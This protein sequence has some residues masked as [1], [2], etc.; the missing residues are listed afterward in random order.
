MDDAIVADSA[1]DAV[2]AMEVQ[3]GLQI[4]CNSDRPNAQ[5]V[6]VVVLL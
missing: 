6:V 4:D 3:V 2:D 5:L 1:M